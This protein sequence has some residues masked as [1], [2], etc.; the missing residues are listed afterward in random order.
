MFNKYKLILLNSISLILLCFILG[1]GS[2]NPVTTTLPTSP[3]TQPPSGSASNE[4]PFGWIIDGLASQSNH[5]YDS[6]F[7]GKVYFISDQTK[8]LPDFSSLSHAG[9]LGTYSLDVPVNKWNYYF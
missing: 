2:S 6:Y 4:T 1:C 3:T 5:D 8:V 7:V 9:E